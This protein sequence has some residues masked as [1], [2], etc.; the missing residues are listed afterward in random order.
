MLVP[1]SNLFSHLIRII[2]AA[3]K[4]W[5]HLD[6]NLTKDLVRQRNRALITVKMVL[7]M[8]PEQLDELRQSYKPRDPPDWYL[9]DRIYERAKAILKRK[10]E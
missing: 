2:E 8:N 1:M 3:E 7:R 4:T 5:L 6:L 10:T 9:M